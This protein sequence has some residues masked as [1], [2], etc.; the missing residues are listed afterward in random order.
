MPVTSC[1]LW[2]IPGIGYKRIIL[3]CLWLLPD[4]HGCYH[5]DLFSYYITYRYNLLPHAADN[6]PLFRIL[7]KKPVRDKGRHLKNKTGKIICK[8]T[9]SQ[10]VSCQPSVVNKPPDNGQL[11]FYRKLKVK[12]VYPIYPRPFLFCFFSGSRFT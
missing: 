8:K 6:G 9:K 3:L 1:P 7:L 5:F 12:L 4:V 10:K 11:T 2:P